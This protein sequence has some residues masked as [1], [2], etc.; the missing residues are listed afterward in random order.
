M[1]E[2]TLEGIY[3]RRL[4]YTYNPS[5]SKHKNRFKKR[6]EEWFTN[7]PLVQGSSNIVERIKEVYGKK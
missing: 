3:T 6:L 1:K 7:D 2:W 4:G 5:S